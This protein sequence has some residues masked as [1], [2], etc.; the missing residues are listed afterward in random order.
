MVAGERAA[1]RNAGS[2]GFASYVYGALAVAI[3]LAAGQ[4]ELLRRPRG[5]HVLELAQCLGMVREPRPGA[6]PEIGGTTLLTVTDVWAVSALQVFAVY[7]AA[8]ALAY[9]LWAERCGEDSLYLSVGLICAVTAVFLL[10]HTAG[11]LLAFG[12]TALILSMRHRRQA[13][14]QGTGQPATPAKVST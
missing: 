14:A 10:H 2:Y 7:L 12:A 1:L 4:F 6:T 8:I 13:R 11:G 3:A 5:G 9:A